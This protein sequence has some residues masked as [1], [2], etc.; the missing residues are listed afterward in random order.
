M[1]LL[2]ET[3]QSSLPKEAADY[4]PILKRYGYLLLARQPM[5]DIPKDM[6]PPAATTPPVFG[7]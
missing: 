2:P 1:I 6:T 4:Q 7:H 5:V 3:L